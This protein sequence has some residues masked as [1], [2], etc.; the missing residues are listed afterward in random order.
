MNNFSK[1]TKRI[2]VSVLSAAFAL[3]A[4]TACSG[5]ASDGGATTTTAT[6]RAERS[7]STSNGESE[8]AL[9]PKNGNRFKIGVIQFADHPSLDNC[10][11]GF[12][13]G[14]KEAGFVEGEQI[15]IDHQSGQADT[16]ITNQIVNSFV[17]QD[18]DLICGIAT[19]AAQ[20]AYNAAGKADIPVI[21]N[22]VSDPVSAELVNA[23]GSNKVGITGVSDALPIKQQLEMM[24]AFLPEAETIGILYSTSETNSISSLAIYEELAPDYGFKIES[25]GINAAADVPLATD[26]LLGKVD[27]LSNLTDNLVVQNMASIVNRCKEEGIPYFGSEEEQ[28]VNGCL[29]A[30]GLDYTELGRQTGTMAANVFQ[31]SPAESMPF[32]T[33]KESQPFYNPAVLSE[34]K[35]TLPA[36]YAAKMIDVSE[37]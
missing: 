19:P 12:V 20:A 27:C 31:G 1:M 11:A 26:Q 8:T 22:A 32:E 14:L 13:E 10:Y 21:F 30:E 23:D 3:T 2:I 37:Q 18:Y 9:K 7:T 36:D 25:L 35:L 33:I 4:F 34:L 16:A 17:S 15:E 28:V 5:N 29:A 24:R 6:E